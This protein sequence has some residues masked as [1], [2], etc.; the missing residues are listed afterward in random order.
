VIQLGFQEVGVE[1]AEGSVIPVPMCG[2]TMEKYIYPR[3]RT[4]IAAET[5]VVITM[6][7]CYGMRIVLIY[8]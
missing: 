8:I 2:W 1:K 6:S 4:V 7:L 3:T 5:I